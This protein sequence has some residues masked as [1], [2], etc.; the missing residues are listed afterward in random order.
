MN[1]QHVEAQLL[2]AENQARALNMLYRRNGATPTHDENQQITDA[3]TRVTTLRRQLQAANGES[4]F[5]QEFTQL[6]NGMWNDRAL[7][8]HS[9]GSQFVR[10]ISQWSEQT[11]G[12]RS[13]QW[14]SPVVSLDI[15]ATTLTEG[16]TSGGAAVRIDHRADTIVPLPLRVPTVADLLSDGETN[17]NAV[18]YPREKTFT[19]AAAT[20]A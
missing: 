10:G 2:E 7:R 3:L 15:M 16:T 6:T 9:L 12:R 5:M 8:G 18:S 13:G 20:V 19:N 4:N 1:T 11:R 17:S 14:T